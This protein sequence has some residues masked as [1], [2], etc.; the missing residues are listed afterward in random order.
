MLQTTSMKQTNLERGFL[1]EFG[2]VAIKRLSKRSSQGL[3]EFMNELKL[4]AKLQ[5]TNLMEVVEMNIQL[6]KTKLGDDGNL[7]LLN[8]RK[9]IIWSTNISGSELAGNPVEAYLQNNGNLILKQGDSPIWESFDDAGGDTLMPGMK[10]KPGKFSWGMDPK[11][12]PQFFIWKE[13]N[14]Y[15]RSNLYQD[16]FT[17]SMYFS[18]SGQTTAYS[19]VAENDEVYFRYV[20]DNPLIQMRFVLTPDGYIEPMLRKTK[21]DQWQIPWKVPRNP[22]ELY[23]RCGSFGSCEKIGL[24]SQSIC[25]CLEGFKPKSQREWDNGNYSA[26]CERKREVR[27]HSK[28]DKF[29]K[30]EKMKWPDFS[31][32]LGNVQG[33]RGRWSFFGLSPCFRMRFSLFCR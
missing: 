15:Y 27:C 14:P 22:C 28:D 17:K 11:G 20:C 9:N 7:Q 10:L 23:A 31:V 2:M 33:V 12:S 4:I 19:F 24:P 21:S 29:K 8:G 32:S 26:G 6:T 3:E 30:L 18:R 13:N 1:S 5:H 25:R 16:G